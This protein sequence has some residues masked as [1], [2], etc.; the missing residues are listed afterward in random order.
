M[1]T[2]EGDLCPS[3]SFRYLCRHSNWLCFFPLWRKSFIPQC[4]SRE[5]IPTEQVK[6]LIEFG[7]KPGASQGTERTQKADGNNFKST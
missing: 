4:E 6:E 2:A 7:V 1:I 5:D 3:K